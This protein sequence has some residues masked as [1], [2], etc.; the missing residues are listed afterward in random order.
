MAAK[1]QIYRPRFTPTVA[2]VSGPPL[3]PVLSIWTQPREAVRFLIQSDPGL[4]V[5]SMA[6]F[7]A[8]S[9]M[10]GQ[11]SLTR[12]YPGDVNLGVMLLLLVLAACVA[13]TVHLYFFSMLFSWVGR[14]LGGRG[15]FQ[16]VR[17]AVA[18]SNVPLVVGVFLIWGPGLC[19]FG[20]GLFSAARPEMS[21]SPDLILS[22]N[23]FLLFHMAMVVWSVAI[24]I[25]GLAEA[26]KLSN[27]R[28]LMIFGTAVGGLAL[29]VFVIYV[30]VS[31]LGDVSSWF[32]SSSREDEPEPLPPTF[33]DVP[34]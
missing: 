5:H 32:E 27:V 33:V 29:L 28:G 15:Q 34:Y 19:I 31:S 24:L 16:E 26:H 1:T 21:A 10:M 22:A 3:N 7:G 14:L 30:M 11:M 8:M 6:V 9:I 2:D 12:S 13:G 18:W 4:F 25:L 23:G 20:K 17:T